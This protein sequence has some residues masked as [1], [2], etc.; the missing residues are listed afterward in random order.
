MLKVYGYSFSLNLLVYNILSKKLNYKS[1]KY[2]PQL[3]PQKLAQ[4]INKDLTI[5]FI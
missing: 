2:Y 4:S 3:F 1:K 5:T